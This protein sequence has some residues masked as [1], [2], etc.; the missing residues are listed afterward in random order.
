MNDFVYYFIG[1]VLSLCGR[2]LSL[3]ICTNTG[4]QIC[5]HHILQAVLSLLVLSLG[6]Q[7]KCLIFT[8]FYSLF[9]C[10]H[11][12]LDRHVKIL[13]HIIEQLLVAGISPHALH[14]LL[15]TLSG[16]A[17]SKTVKSC[18]KRVIMCQSTSPEEVHG[19]AVAG[20]LQEHLLE[21]LG[22]SLDT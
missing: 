5:G 16:V 20:R 7:Y 19:L 11:I 13:G 6:L 3:C 9:H 2:N 10:L 8:A 21:P 12:Y 22:N 15:G 1:R 18:I 14:S 4:V 17:E